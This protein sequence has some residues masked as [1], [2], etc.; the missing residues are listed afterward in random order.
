[1]GAH[2]GRN[3]PLRRAF[4]AL[5]RGGFPTCIRRASRSS[6]RWWLVLGGG[7]G[8]IVIPPPIL[9]KTELGPDFRAHALNGLID[10]VVLQDWYGPV[11][12][13]ELLQKITMRSFAV[14]AALD[15]AIDIVRPAP[16]AL[17]P[18][19]LLELQCLAHT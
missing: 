2:P 14:L 6:I 17:D 16:Q 1:M 7:A 3:L 5:L 11:Q 18:I 4:L 19:E 9:Q 12:G 13:A 8:F 10:H 15:A